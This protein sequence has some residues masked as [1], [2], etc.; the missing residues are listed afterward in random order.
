MVQAITDCDQENK[1]FEDVLLKFLK[2]LKVL[3]YTVT[4]VELIEPTKDQDKEMG[5]KAN[6]AIF[7]KASFARRTMF[8][9]V[10]KLR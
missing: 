8:F 4:P 9:Q 10:W 6:Y 5:S 2:F 7:Q 1:Y 3:Y